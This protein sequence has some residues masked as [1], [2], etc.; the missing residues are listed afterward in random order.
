MHY[1]D[2]QELL[3]WD[4]DEG[5]PRIEGMEDFFL[6]IFSEYEYLDRD[7]WNRGDLHEDNDKF[8]EGFKK[9]IEA[10]WNK[11]EDLI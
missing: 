10:F 2:L 8:F 9:G 6:D 4:P 11:V 3:E 1:T 7:A 5:A